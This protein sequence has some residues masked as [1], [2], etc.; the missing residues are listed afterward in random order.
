VVF[1]G[2]SIGWNEQASRGQ[3]VWHPPE[4]TWGRAASTVTWTLNVAE[5]GKYYLW[6]RVLAPDPQTD[7][8]YL[9]VSTAARTL[10]PQSDWH[11]GSDPG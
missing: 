10:V 2:M 6:G 11:T 4:N 7:S 9:K 1:P 5:A 3:F 8:F